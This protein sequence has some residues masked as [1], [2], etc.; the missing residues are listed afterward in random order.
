MTVIQYVGDLVYSGYGEEEFYNVTVKPSSPD[1]RSFVGI[2]HHVTWE[3]K[4]KDCL[5]V[6]DR[7]GGPAGEVERDG[8]VIEG[9][10]QDYIIDT[11]YGTQF[12]YNV[13]DFVCLP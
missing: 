10:Y 12:K 11:P 6:G 4:E 8:S 7:Q 1:A 3:W 13:F 5:Y 9:N 2:K